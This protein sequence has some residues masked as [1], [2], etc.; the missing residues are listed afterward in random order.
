MIDTPVICSGL[1][2]NKLKF[3]DKKKKKMKKLLQ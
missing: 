2:T 1:I 3:V